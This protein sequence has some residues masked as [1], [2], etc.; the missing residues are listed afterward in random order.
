MTIQPNVSTYAGDPAI[1][2]TMFVALTDLNLYVTPYNISKVNPHV[3][4]GPALYQAG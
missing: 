1:N 2:G 4:A 3:A